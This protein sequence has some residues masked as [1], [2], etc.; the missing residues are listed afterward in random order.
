MITCDHQRMR[1]KLA[2]DRSHKL[3]AGEAELEHAD[4]CDHVQGDR[5]RMRERPEVN[6]AMSL[7]RDMQNWTTKTSV[8]T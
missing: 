4:G 2:V 6:K 1:E 7:P 3:A 8:I 5:Q